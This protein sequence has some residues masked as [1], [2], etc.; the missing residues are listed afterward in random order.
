MHGTILAIQLHIYKAWIRYLLQYLLLFELLRSLVNCS[1]L[2]VTQVL[3]L[4][5]DGVKQVVVK[6]IPTTP[7][8]SERSLFGN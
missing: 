1:L 3:I 2:F 4:L 8:S 7:D 6:A 5:E